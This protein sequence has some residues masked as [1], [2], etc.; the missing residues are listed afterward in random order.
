[1]KSPNPKA[2][3]SD[4]LRPNR[5]QMISGLRAWLDQVSPR[6]AS[7]RRVKFPINLSP[8]LQWRSGMGAAKRSFFKR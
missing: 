3:E 7:I 5:Q 4:G 6:N 2:R 8:E 1:M